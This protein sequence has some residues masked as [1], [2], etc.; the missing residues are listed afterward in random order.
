[1]DGSTT[2][3]EFVAQIGVEQTG[4]DLDTLP[5]IASFQGG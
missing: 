5:N 1:M 4:T 3:Y 2:N